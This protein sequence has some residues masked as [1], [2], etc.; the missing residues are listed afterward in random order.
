[1]G[2][3]YISYLTYSVAGNHRC[4]LVCHIHGQREAMADAD[5]QKTK[6]AWQ[7]QRGGRLV[8]VFIQQND[9]QQ[10]LV[11]MVSEEQALL[12]RSR[13]GEVLGASD[14][15]LLAEE[16]DAGRRKPR[17]RRLAIGSQLKRL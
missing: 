8:F 11:I 6:P 14:V 7:E 9:M 2:S 5:S 12:Q 16:S 13:P 3:M 15:S 10:H 4:A 17:N 1:M